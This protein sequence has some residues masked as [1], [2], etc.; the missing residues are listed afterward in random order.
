PIQPAIS[1]RVRPQPTQCEED[2]STTHTLLH[3]LSMLP[4]LSI[5]RA[6]STLRRLS[7]LRGL[8]ISA[9]TDHRPGAGRIRIAARNA[10]VVIAARRR[11]GA[12]PKQP[13]APVKLRRG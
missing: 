9:M 8:S 1:A 10:I 12:D 6:L 7:R 11:S 4:G 2:G 3:G 5:S 13:L